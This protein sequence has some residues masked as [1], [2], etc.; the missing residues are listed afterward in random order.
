MSISKTKKTIFFTA[1]LFWIALAFFNT[2]F[3]TVKTVY[4]INDWAFLSDTEKREKIFGELY[5][6]LVFVD[7]HTDDRKKVLLYA[8]DVRTFY[9]GRYYLYPNY[10]STAKTKKETI[11][12]SKTKK[13]QY[14]ALFNDS[15]NSNDYKK[16]ASF[17][18]QKSFT[19]GTLYKLK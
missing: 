11:E 12:Q 8:N 17:S 16:I 18:S 1:L 15:L 14:I 19:Y 10:I 6:F 9:L 3:N 7:D 4:E 5:D 13:F 2:F